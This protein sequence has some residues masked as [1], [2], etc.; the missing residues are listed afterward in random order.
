MGAADPLSFSLAV[1]GI[2]NIG[3][4]L[5]CIGISWWV[6]QQVRLDVFLRQP[7]SPQAKLLQVVL[8]IALGYQ[9]ARFFIDYLNWASLMKGIV[10]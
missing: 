9:L 6:L 10:S 2:T 1:S 5:V 3:I 4:V 8:T 7:K